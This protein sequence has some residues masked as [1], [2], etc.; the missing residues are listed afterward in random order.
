MKPA[1]TQ[2]RSTSGKLFGFDRIYGKEKLSDQAYMTRVWIGRLRLHIFHRG[3][4]DPDCHDHP[5]DFWTYP[6]ISY[7]EEVV[8]YDPCLKINVTHVQ[9]VRAFRWSFRPATH[10]HR[11]LGPW[12]GKFNEGGALGAGNDNNRALTVGRIVTLV[13]RGREYREWGFFK[14]RKGR[15][16]WVSFRDYI[17]G[18][19]KDTPCL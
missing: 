18:S 6:L 15:W 8:M 14:K 12:S 10:C 1:M 4:Q 2:N 19:G 13:W 17:Y 16:C 3:D 11:V 5:W 7:L 9:I